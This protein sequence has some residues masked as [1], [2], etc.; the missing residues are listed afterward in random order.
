MTVQNLVLENGMRVVLAPCE[1]ESI[2]FGLFVASGSRHETAKTAGISHFIEHM[3]FKGTPTRTA[4]DI[5]QAVE[6]RGGHINAFTGEEKTV[7]YAHMPSDYLAETID[8]LSDI[9]LRATFPADEFAR[10]KGVILEEIKMY[11][12]DPSSVALEKLQSCLYPDS[13]LGMSV[14]GTPASLTP[15]TPRD[16]KRD[17]A[18]RYRPD[19]T[20]AILVGRFDP[21]TARREMAR[22]FPRRAWAK[23]VAAPK[24]ETFRRII[25]ESVVRRDIKQ[26]QLALGYRMGGFNAS[27]K[28]QYAISLMAAILGRGAMSR[29]FQ[30]VREKRGLCY[31][32]SARPSPF[33]ETGYFA[34]TA[35][36]D[37]KN[38]AALVKTID[39]KIARICDHRVGPEELKRTKDFI[40]GN[41]RLSHENV[42]AK[43]Y[44]LGYSMLSYGRIIS[45]DEQVKDLRAVTADDVQAVAREVFRP[46]RRVMS[47][48]LPK[49]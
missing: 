46:A 19:N 6:G 48:V 14:A 11:D 35:G 5:T 44:F 34:I 49:E 28:T 47:W 9:Y 4:L 13:M 29:L 42:L 30:E 10:E 31:D 20:I 8:L 1:A 25:R 26:A 38:R 3:L 21:E 39:R 16:L 18:L 12:D 15:M 17:K 27:A 41:F 22:R 43:L 33:R 45:V 24:K 23:A 32:I 37:M 7:Y 40:I 36:V 2:A